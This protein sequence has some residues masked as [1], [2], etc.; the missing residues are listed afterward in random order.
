MTDDVEE[1]K[2]Q[3]PEFWND[4]R[5][6][7]EQLRKIARLKNW[8][9]GYTDVKT[10]VDD[11]H[12]LAEFQEAGET[13]EE[14]VSDQYETALRLTEA[15]ESKNMLRNEDGRLVLTD[16]VMKIAK[17]NPA[18]ME[19]NWIHLQDGTECAFAGDL[20]ITP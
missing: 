17:Y 2:T 6:A 19:R 16:H 8:V 11:L 14:E 9:D 18:I 12:V 20:D 10:A 4:P 1:Q 5:S 13:S 15:L 3:D 7:E